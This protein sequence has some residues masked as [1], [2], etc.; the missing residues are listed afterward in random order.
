[1]SFHAKD[2]GDRHLL[3]KMLAPRILH[4]KQHCPVMLIQNMSDSLVNGS[5]GTVVGCGDEGPVVQFADANVTMEIKATMFSGNCVIIGASCLEFI[6]LSSIAPTHARARTHTCV[7][8][9]LHE[10]QMCRF[11]CIQ[12]QS[13]TQCTCICSLRSANK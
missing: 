2:S 1:M 4:V 9:K 5:L 11:P 3:K 13:P 7:A 10:H 6:K 8:Y 12:C